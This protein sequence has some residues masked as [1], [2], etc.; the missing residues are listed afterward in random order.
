M[1][2][3]TFLFLTDYPASG[4]LS[5]QHKE[6][7]NHTISLYLYMC[8]LWAE[9]GC[10][11]HG[12][13]LMDWRDFQ[14]CLLQKLLLSLLHLGFILVCVTPTVCNRLPSSCALALDTRTLSGAF[15]TLPTNRT[16]GRGTLII[17]ALKKTLQLAFCRAEDASAFWQNSPVT[18]GSLGPAQFPDNTGHATKSC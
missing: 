17:F 10:S 14:G 11:D 3:E 4:I 12:L 2:K 9:V 5:Q 8:V 7:Q 15:S 6:K 13:H 18:A 16:G 1:T